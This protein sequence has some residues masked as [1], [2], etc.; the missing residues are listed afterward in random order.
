MNGIRY[1]LMNP[2]G[3]RTALVL[4]P[5]EEADRER[6]TGALIQKSEQVGYLMPP[7]HQ[8][9]AGRLRMMGGEFCGNASM[10][11]AAFLLKDALAEG[12]ERRL[13]L[14]VSGAE[15]PVPCLI[16]R[17]REGWTGTVD[18]PLPEEIR[19]LNLDGEVF[20]AVR[21]PGILHVIDRQENR[22]GE[23][24]ETLLRKA[25]SVFPD[26]ALGLLRWREET[27]EMTPLVYVRDSGT[28]VWE[29]ACGSGSTALACRKTVQTGNPVDMRIRQPGGILRVRTEMEKE[30]IRRALLTGRVELE[31]TGV[32]SVYGSSSITG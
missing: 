32:L 13:L 27:E 16:R 19:E 10:A 3:N 22:T 23:E 8:P 15:Q 28:M 21:L 30:K 17:E 31:E 12:E 26:P 24:A 4:D 18:M 20:T 1:A 5:V 7:R 29:S 11:A 25:A 6:V 9:S 14:E 2:S